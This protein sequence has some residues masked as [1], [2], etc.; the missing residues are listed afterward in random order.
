MVPVLVVLVHLLQY[1]TGFSF[2][3]KHLHYNAFD[4]SPDTHSHPDKMQKR[5]DF[6]FILFNYLAA[7]YSTSSGSAYHDRIA[8]S[9]Q[10]LR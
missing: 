3:S 7:I 9:E 1:Y 4:S 8:T 10:L 5:S 2:T 6:C